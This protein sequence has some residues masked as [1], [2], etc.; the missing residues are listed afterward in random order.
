LRKDELVKKL[1]EEGIVSTG[2]Y[3][4]VV[5]LGKERNIPIFEED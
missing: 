3:Q 4:A 5:K 2:N 1:G